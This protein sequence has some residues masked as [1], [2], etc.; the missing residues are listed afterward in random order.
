M[1]VRY[2]LIILLMGFA[3]HFLSQQNDS[4]ALPLKTENY[5]SL[6]YDNDFFCATDRYY[7]QGIKFNFI[8]PVIKYSPFTFLLLKFKKS[9]LNYYGLHIEQDVF[10]PRS[11]RYNGGQVYYGERPF[12]AVFFVSHSLNSFVSNKRILLQTQLDIGIIGPDAKGEEE[13]KGIH[14]ALDN[15]QPQGWQNQLSGDYIINYRLKFEKGIISKKHIELMVSALTRIGTLYTDL[16]TGIH[17]RVGILSSYFKNL[18]LEKESLTRKND[19]KA[20]AIFKINGKLVG[21]NATLQGGLTNSG[22]VYELPDNSI[23]RFV[24]DVSA[25]IVLAYK[26]VSLQYGK[27]YIT[28]EFNGG[29]DHGWGNCAVTVCF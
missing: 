12:T 13:Q 25:G 20:F 29:L 27:T 1:T 18:G 24:A 3:S 28:P 6:N 4:L 17:L 16:A 10:T 8:H 11:I 21:Y 26:R 19:F 7:T 22:N 14:R 23:S 9:N 5:L 2:C 15:I